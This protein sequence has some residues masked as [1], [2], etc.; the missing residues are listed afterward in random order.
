MPEAIGCC[1][2]TALYNEVHQVPGE[3]LDLST[4]SHDLSDC[5]NLGQSSELI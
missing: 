1:Q 3:K 5:T 2:S 4:V